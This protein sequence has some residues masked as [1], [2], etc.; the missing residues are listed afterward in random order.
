VLLLRRSQPAAPKLFGMLAIGQIQLE[1]LPRGG[2]L[3]LVPLLAADQ[4]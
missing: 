4:G 2:V 3:L 1:L